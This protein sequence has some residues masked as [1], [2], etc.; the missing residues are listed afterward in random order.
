MPFGDG[1]GPMGLGPMSGRGAGFCAGFVRPASANPTPGYPY[2]YGYPGAA[3]A[4]PVRGYGYGRGFGRGMGR[5]FGR[6]WRR[7]GPYGY[8]Y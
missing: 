1:T 7:W 4:W 8:P 2:G 6:G 3:P 5:G